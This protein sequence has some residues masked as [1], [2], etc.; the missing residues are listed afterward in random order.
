MNKLIA[1]LL[2]LNLVAVGTGTY[3]ILEELDSGYDWMH[4]RYTMLDKSIETTGYRV[5]NVQTMLRHPLVCS[6]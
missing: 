3:L 4:D 5:E 1:L 2:T 6:E